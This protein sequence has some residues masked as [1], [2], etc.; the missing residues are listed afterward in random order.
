V[1]SGNVLFSTDE[2]NATMLTK[3]IEEGISTACGFSS[4]V[5]IRTAGEL[6]RILTSNPFLTERVE[7]SSKLHVTF[8]YQPVESSAWSKVSAP[9]G[10]KDEFAPGEKEVFLFCPNG[11]GRTKLSN[12][13]FERKLDVPV[14]TRN[15][16]TVEA[17]Y[18]MV[19]DVP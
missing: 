13:F 15:W 5:F 18:R 8:L 14:T 11:Y 4:R 17:L 2:E 1:Q 6:Q 9:Q 19:Q 16:N 7:D 12:S 3:K 10:G